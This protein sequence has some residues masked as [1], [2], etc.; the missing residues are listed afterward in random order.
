MLEI[1]RENDGVNGDILRAVERIANGYLSA[2]TSCKACDKAI[3]VNNALVKFC[4]IWR[5]IDAS[6]NT[7]AYITSLV[8]NELRMH[9]R[10]LILKRR[11][12]K[13]EIDISNSRY[14][15]FQPAPRG[16]RSECRVG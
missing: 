3:V 5:R 13:D 9:N 15:A 1:C 11:I 12:F 14:A 4:A 6:K 7:F 2:E 8:R 10:S 16:V